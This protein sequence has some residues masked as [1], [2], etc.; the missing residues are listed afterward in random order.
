M[1]WLS[2]AVLIGIFGL[3]NWSRHG[4]SRAARRVS[5]VLGTDPD[6]MDKKFHYQGL[7]ISQSLIVFGILMDGYF[8]MDFGGEE[9]PVLYIWLIF[10]LVVQDMVVMFQRWRSTRGDEEYKGH[11]LLGLLLYLVMLAAACALWWG[12]R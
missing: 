7:R 11:P 2:L 9:I 8:R 6:E 12:A 3:M 1:V 10:A 4:R 5:E